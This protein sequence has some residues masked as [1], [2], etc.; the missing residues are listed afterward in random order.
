MVISTRDDWNVRTNGTLEFHGRS[1]EDWVG[2]DREGVIYAI[3]EETT[4]GD[5][6]AT[7]IATEFTRLFTAA[8]GRGA[9]IQSALN[10]CEEFYRKKG[11]V[12]QG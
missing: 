12:I 7:V 4:V 9:L 1:V 5:V 11:L 2:A 10:G 3:G 8:E 6:T